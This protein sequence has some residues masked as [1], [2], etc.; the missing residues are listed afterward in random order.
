MIIYLTITNYILY[1][2]P[3][4]DYCYLLINA[5]GKISLYLA[6]LGVCYGELDE[7]FTS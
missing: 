7:Y 5:K 4:N 3:F 6:F 2:L 1:S